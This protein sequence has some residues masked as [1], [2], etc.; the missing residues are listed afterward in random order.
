MKDSELVRIMLQ[1]TRAHTKRSM[2]IM[3]LGVLQSSDFFIFVREGSSNQTV[4]KPMVYRIWFGVNQL[5]V[6]HNLVAKRPTALD[7][8][9]FFSCPAWTRSWANSGSVSR[10]VPVDETTGLF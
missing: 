1:D 7:M 10:K 6:W 4:Q 5:A 2:L 3:F 8:T 9:F